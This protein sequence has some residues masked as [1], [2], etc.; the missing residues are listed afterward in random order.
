[1]NTEC[2]YGLYPHAWM[3]DAMLVLLAYPQIV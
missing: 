2:I 1:L 3:I